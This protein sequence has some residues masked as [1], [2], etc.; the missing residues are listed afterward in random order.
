MMTAG[1]ADGISQE[2]ARMAT[3]P[4]GISPE[5]WRRHGMVEAM[6]RLEANP[7]WRRMAARTEAFWGL[8]AP[9]QGVAEQP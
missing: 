3:V 6:E 1:F 8:P 2:G 9:E 5:E 7:L 4:E